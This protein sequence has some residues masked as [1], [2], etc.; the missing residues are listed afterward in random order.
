MVF[1]IQN[2]RKCNNSKFKILLIRFAFFISSNLSGKYVLQIPDFFF[3]LKFFN[4][5]QELY[6][7]R[8]DYR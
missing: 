8:V 4:C 7:P 2:D 3:H 5:E 1:Q 6:I